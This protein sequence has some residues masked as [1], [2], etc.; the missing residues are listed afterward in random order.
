M[1]V[2]NPHEEGTGGHDW[3]ADGLKKYAAQVVAAAGAACE[4]CQVLCF[5]PSKFPWQQGVQPA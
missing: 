1:V 3:L 4:N 2:F 5:L